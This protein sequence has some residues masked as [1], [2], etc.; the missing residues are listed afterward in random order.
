MPSNKSIQIKTKYAQ[1]VFSF[2]RVLKSKKSNCFWKKYVKVMGGWE[3]SDPISD[4]QK[5]RRRNENKNEYLHLSEC[6]R[7]VIVIIYLL[8]FA[9]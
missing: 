8:V 5:S 7:S 9:V 2:H 1:Q 6:I 3:V 4:I